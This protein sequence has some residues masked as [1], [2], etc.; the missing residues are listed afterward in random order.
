MS[1]RGWRWWRTARTT[2]ELVLYLAEADR[3]ESERD[4]QDRPDFIIDL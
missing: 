2:A 3:D 4:R 1:G